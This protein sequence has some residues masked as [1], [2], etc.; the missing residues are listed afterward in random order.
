MPF[1]KP[2]DLSSVSF[3][4]AGD[5]ERQ[6]EDGQTPASILVVKLREKCR[7]IVTVRTP[8]AED[9]DDP[10]RAGK[11][12]VRRRAEGAAEIAEFQLFK[13]YSIGGSTQHEAIG[14]GSL[15][16]AGGGPGFVPGVARLEIALERA[17]RLDGCVEQKSM[18]PVE[19]R[20]TKTTGF[21]T[22]GEEAVVSRRRQKSTHDDAVGPLVEDAD[23]GLVA[24]GK[25]NLPS[26]GDGW[27]RVGIFL[28][29]A[30]R[31]KTSN[32]AGIVFRQIQ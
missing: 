1:D 5:F 7:G 27:M 28:N 9:L 22:A 21:I 17:V 29:L 11:G 25:P 30:Q 6:A 2:A 18:C 24:P 15:V 16:V 23:R 4:I 20:K 26:T 31:S 8:G 12:R 32:R 19:T 3:E 13:G 14:Q 10:N